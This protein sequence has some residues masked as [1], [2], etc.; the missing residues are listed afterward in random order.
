MKTTAPSSLTTDRWGTGYGCI[1]TI[2]T[3]LA[4]ALFLPSASAQRE[5]VTELQQQVTELQAEIAHLEADNQKK[6]LPRTW[7]LTP[8]QLAWRLSAILALVLLN[9]FF[10]A[11]EFA[12]VKVRSSQLDALAKSGKRS[13]KHSLHIAKNLDAYLSATQLGITIASLALG[14]LGEP[15]I[16]GLISPAFHYLFPGAGHALLHT[17][18]FIIAFSIVTFL[19]IVLG[20]LT[21]KSLAIRESL[22]TTLVVSRPLQFF[23]V[24]F[25]PAIFVL[26]KAANYFLKLVFRIDPAS[27]GELAHSTEELRAIVEATH[28]KESDVTDTE[29][30]ILANTLE[31]SDLEVRQLMTP[32]NEVVTLDVNQSFKENWEIAKESKHT[33]FPL[34]NGH[35]DQTIGIVH[36]KDMITL[37]DEKEPD[38]KSIRMDFSPVPEYARVDKLLSYFLDQSIHLTIV[39][40]EFGGAVGV[41]TMEDLLEEVV[42]EIRDEFDEDELAHEF[43]RHSEDEFTVKGTLALH[44]MRDLCGLEL[45]GPDVTTI[46]GYVTQKLGRLPLKD[47]RVR[48]E[49]YTVTVVETDGRRVIELRFQRGKT[50][51]AVPQPS[52]KTTAH[53]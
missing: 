2:L 47:E 19:H 23:Y 42:G 8:G 18:S 14:W 33:R 9:G 46:G 28:Q 45:E 16:A 38:L 13:A 34:I 29:R 25:K 53:L 32:R 6:D 7:T 39:V 44:E 49:D 21:P 52:E 10:V 12:I 51:G 31:L 20:E 17:T 5:S 48:V 22:R 3:F 11:S 4:L 1:A 27:D 30:Q 26:N 40:D 37:L 24:I 41:V 43:H 35:L 36:I 15:Y 50:K